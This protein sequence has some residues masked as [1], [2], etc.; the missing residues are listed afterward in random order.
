MTNKVVIFKN[1]RIGD[2]I[3]SAQSVKLIIEKNKDKEVILYLSEIN[4]KMKFLF[5]DKNV[6]IILV[7]YKLSLKNRIEILH[8]FLRTN[9][10]K[11]YVLRPKNFF[12]IL[13]IIFYYKK[14]EFFGF[15]INGVKNYR[16]P[17][18]FFRKF[19]SKFVI[20]D[21]STIKKRVSR[22]RLHLNLVDEK[23]KN[24]FFLKINNYKI[25]NTLKKILPKNYLLIHYKKQIF[26]E[27][28][29]GVEGL[30]KIMNEL[31]NYYPKIV[32]IND[33]EPSDDNM[34][35]KKK[36][37]WYDFKRGISGYNDPNILYLENIEGLDFFNVIRLS[38]KT[39]ACHGTITLIGYIAKTSILDLFYCKIRNNNDYY[40]Y[41]NSF[42]E[43]VPYN[44]NYNFIIPKKDLDKTINRI[45]FYFKNEK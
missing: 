23:S 42:H 38:K 24:D 31:L 22:E 6:K 12:F 5:N 30:N 44:K 39:I 37:T 13:P 43:H 3:L 17:N 20:N 45:K 26:E 32:L 33:I 16:R 2:L 19:L 7:D 27:L 11:V 8:F 10:S 21:R 15:C 4:Y 28:G 25:S 9:I 14:T 18:I 29:W 35:F 34:I 41:K 36:Y 40:R 1:D